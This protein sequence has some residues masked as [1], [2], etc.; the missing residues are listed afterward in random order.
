MKHGG[1]LGIPD[2][3]NSVFPALMATPS[4]LQYVAH[5]STSICSPDTVGLRRIISSAYMMMPVNEPFKD[6][7]V[8]ECC[9]KD[10]SRSSV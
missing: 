1:L 9:S 8:L 5:S 10:E 2:I 4:P 6:V 3:R 7:P